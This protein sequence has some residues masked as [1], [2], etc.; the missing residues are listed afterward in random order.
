MGTYDT[1]A[2]VQNAVLP[3]SLSP[4]YVFRTSAG[5]QENH[6]REGKID[7]SLIKQLPPQSMPGKASPVMAMG[8]NTNPYIQQQGQ[9]GQF[10][11]QMSID[12]KLLQA[13]SQFG[14]VGAAAAV[15]V[16][17]SRG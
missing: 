16:A 3:R 17:A 15:S 11:D 4:R 5:N 6:V 13:Q 7:S 12:S 8:L 1:R 14:A 10:S 2:Y 9:A